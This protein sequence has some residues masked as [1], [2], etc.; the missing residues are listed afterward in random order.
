MARDKLTAG[1]STNAAASYSTGSIAPG[2]GRLV[3]AFVANV[4]SGG[5]PAAAPTLAGNG[6]AWDQV[7]SLQLAG[8]PDHRL[9]CF[10]AMGGAPAAG[11]ITLDFGGQQQGACAWSVFEYD[12]VDATGSNGSGAVAQQQTKTAGGTSLAVALVPLADAATSTVVG[13]VLLA[14]NAAVS[15][16][17]G[18]AE[19]DQ[20]PFAKGGVR[21]TLE[22]EDR[23]GGGSTADWSWTP[24]ANAAA[25]VLEVKAAAVIVPVE[26][27]EDTETLARRFEPV[28]YFHPDERF[29]PSDAKRYLEQCALWKA[30]APFDV[31][32]SWG[33][34]GAPYDRSPL[35]GYGKI[36]AVAG[37]IGTLLGPGNLV[38]T[39]T[40]ERFLD[41]AGWKDAAGTAQPKVTATSKN[42]YS[43]RDAVAALYNKPDGA[44]GNRALRDSRFWYHAELF[45]GDRLRRLLATVRAPDLVK[46]LDSLKNAALLCYYFFYPAHEEPLEAICKNVEGKEF[47]GF[48][49]EWECLAILLERDDPAGMSRPSFIGCSGRLLDASAG[50]VAQAA[51]EADAAKRVWMKVRP[52]AQA[53]PIGEH[54][55]LFVSNGTHSLYLEPGLHSVTYPAESRPYG[56]GTYEGTPPPPPPPAETDNPMEAEG[57]LWA[58][59]IAGNG[60]LGPLGATVGLVWGIVEAAEGNYGLGVVG[61]AELDESAKDDAGTP[62]AGKVVKPK[63]LAVPDAGADVQDWSSARGLETDGRRYDFVVDRTAQTWWP[64]DFDQGGYRGRWGARVETDPFG[65]RAGMRFP[66]FW[67]MFFLAFANGKTLG[68]F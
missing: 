6:L 32:D 22:T 13:A 9:S 7:A 35:I 45:E 46:V 12:N 4:R 18:L 17:A 53:Q 57:I 41:L 30:E 1:S 49:G 33:G 39:A 26:P 51:D 43:N 62:G 25:I 47:G 23:V 44:G 8:S 64:A 21:G 16:G 55:R 68:L 42:T 24:S 37:E 61:T 59:V 5:G 34:K 3:L 65:R 28:L 50:A 36:A 11:A 56:C 48:A 40:E 31:K 63:D 60:L 10:R 66:A 19:I 38:D 20:Q 29:F 27:Q 67:R 58:K 15:P 14:T 54:P 2:A 52:F